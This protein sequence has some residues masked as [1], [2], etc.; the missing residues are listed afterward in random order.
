MMADLT[1]GIVTV[2]R[3]DKETTGTGFVVAEDLVVTCA[4]VI[5]PAAQPKDGG[6]ARMWSWSS[7][8]MAGKP[9]RCGPGVVA[10]R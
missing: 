6:P 5:A 1:S 9:C 2:L 4:H 7:G 8:L 3:P 10:A